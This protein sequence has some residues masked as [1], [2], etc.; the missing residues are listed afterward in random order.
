M[1]EGFVTG[2]ARITMPYTVDGFNHKCRLYGRN[3][4]PVSGSFNINSRNVDDNDQ[5]WTDAAAGMEYAVSC[6]LPSAVTYSPFLLEK[7]DGAV[8]EPL[9][10]TTL[11]PTNATGSYVKASQATVTFKDTDLLKL[12]LV[13]VEGTEA[14]AQKFRSV[15]GG[16]GAFDLLIAEFL[17]T[18]TGTHAPYVWAVS[19]RNRYLSTSPFVSASVWPNRKIARRRGV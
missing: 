11:T 19:H 8:W 4:Q 16:D 17:S 15:T 3:V 6:I 10:N 2:M 9:A 14:L 18:H 1:P 7:W 5:V 13:V 12:K